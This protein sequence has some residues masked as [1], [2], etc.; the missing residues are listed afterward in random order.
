MAE[1]T[2]FCVTEKGEVYVLDIKT[3][4]YEQVLATLRHIVTAH[5]EIPELSMRAVRLLGFPL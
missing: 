1:Y 4:D 2:H 3:L 5:P